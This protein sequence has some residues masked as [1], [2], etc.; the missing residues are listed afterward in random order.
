MAHLLPRLLR[1]AR[2]VPVLVPRTLPEPV[3]GLVLRR[4]P[5]RARAPAGPAPPRA[6]RVAPAVR[7]R[8]AVPPGRPGHAPRSRARGPG[9][10]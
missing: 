3:P 2:P 1:A 5:A 4:L 8:V 9:W 10:V 7:V 6:V